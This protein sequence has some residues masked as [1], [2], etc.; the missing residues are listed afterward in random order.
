[1]QVHSKRWDSSASVVSKATVIAT[2]CIQT[3]VN[4][5]VNNMRAAMIMLSQVKQQSIRVERLSGRRKGF[6]WQQVFPDR[7]L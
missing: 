4:G 7:P 6:L 1:M 2:N 3:K 5:T